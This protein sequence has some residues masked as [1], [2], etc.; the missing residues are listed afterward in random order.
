MQ[1]NLY[2]LIEVFSIASYQLILIDYLTD[3]FDTI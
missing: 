3:Y 1:N 2:N